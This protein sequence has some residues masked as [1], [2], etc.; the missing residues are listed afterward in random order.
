L[1]NDITWQL[2]VGKRQILCQRDVWQTTQVGSASL[3]LQGQLKV[4]AAPV[5]VE[6]E[7]DVKR[8]E[9]LQASGEG[10]ACCATQARIQFSHINCTT[11]ESSTGTKNCPKN[12]L[13]SQGGIFIKISI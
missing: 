12:A 11:K 8:V 2:K 5:S 4:V 6:L 1:T 7:L 13:H 10:V 9:Q 3:H